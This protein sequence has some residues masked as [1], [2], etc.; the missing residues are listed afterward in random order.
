MYPLVESVRIENRQLHH[1][2]LH[3]RRINHAIRAVY[4]KELMVDIEA[5]VKI[6]E[7]LSADRYKCR[8]N[9]YPDKVDYTIIPYTQREIKSLKV[10]VDN[11]IDYTFKSENRQQ[12]DVSFLK[13]GNC[14]DIIIIKNGHIT[15]AWAANILLFDGKDWF[16]P[17]TPLLKGV[18]REFLLQE[19]KIKQREITTGVLNIF[20]KVKLINAMIDFERAPEISIPEGIFF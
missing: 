8:L 11:T 7:N 19:E 2:D 6:P 14:D 5:I 18:Q 15:D 1:I 4:G 13:R 16:T 17:D 12:L 3:N 10:I 9:F 20:Q